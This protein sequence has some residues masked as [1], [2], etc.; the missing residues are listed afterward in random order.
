MLHRQLLM[1]AA[2]GGG[3]LS[4]YAAVSSRLQLHTAGILG[5]LCLCIVVAS[6]EY[7]TLNIIARQST[8]H[9]SITYQGLV[10]FQN[11]IHTDS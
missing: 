7:F 3:A 6:V 11:C 10:R 5:G 1:L 4:R 8:I 9:G 2:A